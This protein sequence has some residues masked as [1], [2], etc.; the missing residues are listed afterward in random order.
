M[1]VQ[2]SIEDYEGEVKADDRYRPAEVDLILGRNILAGLTLC[3]SPWQGGIALIS[4]GYIYAHSTQFLRTTYVRDTLPAI[5]M[6]ESQ[7]PTF[8]ARSRSTFAAAHS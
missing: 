7:T 2:L 5:A 4:T 1:S 8:S 3:A 6:A